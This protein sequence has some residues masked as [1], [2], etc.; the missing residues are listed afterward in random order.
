MHYAAFCLPSCRRRAEL[1]GVQKDL[2]TNVKFTGRQQYK[3]FWFCDPK[4]E[5]FNLELRS[6]TEDGKKINTKDTSEISDIEMLLLL[7]GRRCEIKHEVLVVI[8]ACSSISRT[9]EGRWAKYRIR[10]AV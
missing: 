4:H 2:L 3:T 7:K 10:R 5:R 6:A 1:N 9:I 8:S